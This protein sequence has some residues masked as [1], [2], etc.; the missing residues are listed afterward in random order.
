MKLLNWVRA[1]ALIAL[2]SAFAVPQPAYGVCEESI[3][4]ESRGSSGCYQEGEVCSVH[5][6]EDG[7][8][9]SQCNGGPGICG[10]PA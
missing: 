9:S 3:V 7:Y 10:D 1:F 2:L 5:Y 4:C 6:C 8:C